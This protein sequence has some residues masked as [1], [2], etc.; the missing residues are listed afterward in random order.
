MGIGPVADNAS[1]EAD[2]DAV[3]LDHDWTALPDGATA[4]RFA[5]PS[6]SLAMVSLGD[7]AHP[8]VVLVPG[9]TGSKE[10]F[11]SV[12]CAPLGGGEGRT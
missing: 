2:L 8:R 11:R 3:L 1:Q 7:P 12:G 6:G 9:V 10:D 5:A 4:S